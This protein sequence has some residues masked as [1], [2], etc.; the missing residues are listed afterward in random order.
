MMRLSLSSFVYFNYRLEDA[1]RRTAAFGYDGIDVWGGRP[2]AYRGD[3]SPEDLRQ[4]RALLDECGLAVPS[5]I[6]AQFR[7]P[8]SLCSPIDAIRHDSIRYIEAGIETARALGSR[9]VSVCPGHTLHGQGVED[10]WARLADSLKRLSDYAA[11][12][13]MRVALEPADRYETDLVQNVEQAHRLLQDVG[14]DSLGIVFDVGHSQIV[15]DDPATAVRALGPALFHVHI[16]DT[17]GQRDDHL[18]PGQGIIDFGSFFA[19]LKDVG[20]SGFLAAELSFNYTI[21]PDEAAQATIEW[22]KNNASS[23]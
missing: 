1:I 16:D 5:F 8:T 12:R 19:A 4:V 2:H 15:G 11:R 9:V 3:R 23:L 18:V 10:G 17:H 21:A 14:S 22:F 20:Y 6:P 7:Y 13:F